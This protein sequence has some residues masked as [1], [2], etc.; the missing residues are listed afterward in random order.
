MDQNKKNFINK[1][2]VS[3]FWR[4]K[5][6]AAGGFGLCLGLLVTAALGESPSSVLEILWAGAFGSWYSFGMTLSYATPLIFTGLAVAI[7]IKAGLFN[8]GAEG[9]LTMGMVAASLVGIGLEGWPPLLA[10]GLI[11]VAA[12]VG[13][14]LWGLIPALMK[15]MRG[16]HEVLTS[17][18]LNFVASGI[19]SWVVLDLV[20]SQD[21]QNPESRP[22]DPR[23][24]LRP[25][26][27]FDGAPVTLVLGGGVLLGAFF[28]WLFKKTVLGYQINSVG[29]GGDR[30]PSVAGISVPWIQ[31][32]VM[33]A[34][35]GAAGLVAAGEL[36]GPSGRFRLGFSPGYGFIGIP[37]ALIAGSHP[38]ALVL[39]AL[40]F[41]ALQKG[42]LDLE[43]ETTT[44]TRD[45]ALVIE[46]LMILAIASGPGWTV[47]V[48]ALKSS[49]RLNV[50][51]TGS[52]AP[53]G[54]LDDR[55]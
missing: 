52:R 8:I 5:P 2:L 29:L 13:G 54:D 20:R 32:L 55:R 7:A 11:I 41:G 33:M 38:I 17:I 50:P 4:L 30:A 37:V 16:S 45:L 39:S 18:M 9:Q 43:L 10:Q 35:G 40:L 48:K 3:I 26:E 19:A 1:Y 15:I 51:A 12:F 28:W 27:V 6:V 46:A 53:K 31:C 36:L 34:A 47:L 14:A 24:L 42:T 21:T 22:I 25:F 23:F 44:I 49:L